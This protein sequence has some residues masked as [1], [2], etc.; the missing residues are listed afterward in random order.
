MRQHPDSQ[1]GQ[2]NE[3]VQVNGGSM[4]S[5]SIGIEAACKPSIATAHV[6]DRKG[7]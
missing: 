1:L 5:S 3:L 6:V 4:T 2:Q 7:P